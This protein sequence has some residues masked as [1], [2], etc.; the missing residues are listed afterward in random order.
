MNFIRWQWWWSWYFALCHITILFYHLHELYRISIDQISCFRHAI[1][2]WSFL[3]VLSLYNMYLAPVMNS[4]AS[5]KSESLFLLFLI[6]IFWCQ[7]LDFL[8]ISKIFW[9]ILVIRFTIMCSH[10]RKGF[11]QPNLNWKKTRSCHALLNTYGPCHLHINAYKSPLMGDFP[12]FREFYICKL[13]K[14]KFK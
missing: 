13:N 6:D 4:C 7:K 8:R 14:F 11:C 1:S 9:D 12:P 3:S 10:L 5:T 2:Y